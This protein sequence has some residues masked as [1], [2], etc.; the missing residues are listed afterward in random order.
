MKFLAI[1]P[2]YN[3]ENTIAKTVEAL[4][5]LKEV[6]VLVVDDCSTDKTAEQ[7]SKSGCKVITNPKNLGKGLSLNQALNGLNFD[8]YS[9]ILLAD[10]D[11]GSSA[12]EF[13]K[14][15]KVFAEEGCDLVIAAFGPPTR[16]GGFGLVKGLARLAIKTNGGR[17]MQTPLSGQRLLST[18]CLKS[19]LPL[20][21]GFGV[22]VD[23]T[24]K[25]LRAG[26]NVKEVPTAMSHKETGRNISGFWHRFR[27]FKDVLKVT[28]G[29]ILRRP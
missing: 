15:I 18:K 21:S 13:N 22:E 19:V 6:E 25:A 3:E 4:K 2:A 17:I 28:L 9:G 26:L 24:I 10:G 23:M 27:Q 11:L 7:A 14:L 5:S 29:V 16:K 12:A 8:G 1:I 20:A